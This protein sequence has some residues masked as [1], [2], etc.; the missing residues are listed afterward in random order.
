MTGENDVRMRA[1]F[2]WLAAEL[3]AFRITSVVI[4]SA[5]ATPAPTPLPAR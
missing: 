4:G 5:S 3:R 2:I 1:R